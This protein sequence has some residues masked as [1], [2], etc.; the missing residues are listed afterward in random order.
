MPFQL[1]P[2]L[3]FHH[4][5]AAPVAW[6]AAHLGSGL[7]RIGNGQFRLLRLR[8]TRATRSINWPLGGQG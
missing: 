1:I 2:A 3:H 5:F 7:S 6:V 4:D 8:N